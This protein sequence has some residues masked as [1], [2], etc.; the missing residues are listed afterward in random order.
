MLLCGWLP[1]V[2]GT[3]VPD[4][5]TTSLLPAGAKINAGEVALLT[6][7]SFPTGGAGRPV[8]PAVVDACREWVCLGSCSVVMPTVSEPAISPGDRREIGPDDGAT[9]Q[10]GQ[11]ECYPTIAAIGNAKQREQSLVL[12][13]G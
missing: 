9:A 1:P 12:L 11:S 5:N 4:D 8:G 6:P 10:V 13:D 3:L 2:G 7:N